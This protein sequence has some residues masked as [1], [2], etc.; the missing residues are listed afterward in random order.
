MPDVSEMISE[1]GDHGFADTGTTRK[2]S[3]IQYAIWQIEATNQWPFLETVLN[4]TFDGTSAV[5][6]NAPAAGSW[7]A[8]LR[9]KDLLT[10]RRIAFSRLDD[11]EDQVGKNYA[12]SGS[13]TLYYFE[14]GQLK[15]WPVPPSGTGTVKWTYTRVSSEI[16]ESTLEAAILIPKSHH[17]LIVVKALS[18]LYR[19]EDDLELAQYFEGVALEL[20]QRMTEDVMR[21]QLDQPDFIRVI[22]PDDYDDLL[23]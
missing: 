1:L 5:P 10:G 13:P 2:V 18:K 6:T 23:L 7:R 8:S 12:Q 16:T 15:L 4:L 21:Q 14:A 9:M 20:L 22:D 17:E 11:F 3:A 19:M